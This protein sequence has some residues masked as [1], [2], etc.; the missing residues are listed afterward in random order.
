MSNAPDDKNFSDKDTEK[1]TIPPRRASRKS[2]R[3]RLNISLNDLREEI[4]MRYVATVA[5]ARAN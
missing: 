2:L 3:E 5:G 4:S 1:L